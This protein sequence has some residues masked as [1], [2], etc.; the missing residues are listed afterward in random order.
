MAKKNKTNGPVSAVIV[1]AGSGTRMGA[2]INKLLLQ[3]CGKSILSYTVNVFEEVGAIDEIVLV[4]KEAEI[5]ALY[6]MAREEGFGK[7][8]SIVAGG[9]TRQE[10]VYRGLLDVNPEAELVAIHDGARALV[11]PEII[12]AC[13][14][15]AKECGAAVCGVPVKD[16]VKRVLPDGA[17]AETVPRD[18]LWLV[19]TPQVF[20][21]ELILN[22][23]EAARRDGFL[24]TDDCVLAER[25][26]ARVQM[27]EGS[28]QNIKITTPQDL[29]LA[30]AI[31]EQ[32][33]QRE[34]DDA[35]R[36]WM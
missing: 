18:D 24:G 1:A 26:G 30:E 21:K 3:I 7:V 31:L 33:Y 25:A 12:E 10:S 23:H 29:A 19:Q 15:R 6:Q 36:L 2:G 5:P 13:L 20:A 28:Y 32:A 27:V 35:D 16:T 22:A 14:L 17:V 9:S 4:A 8:K 34:E 11:S